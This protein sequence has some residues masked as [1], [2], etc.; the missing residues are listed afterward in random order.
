[1]IEDECVQ[2]QPGLNVITGES[3]AG[4]SVLVEAFGQVSFKLSPSLLCEV[5][6]LA[7]VCFVYVEYFLPMQIVQSYYKCPSSVI[8]LNLHYVCSADI[9]SIHLTA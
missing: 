6:N 8:T 9:T 1:M 2:F 5:Y 3:G 4:K 7:A